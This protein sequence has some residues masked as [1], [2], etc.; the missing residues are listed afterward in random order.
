MSAGG[1]TG[2]DG[3]QAPA[4]PWAPAAGA[5]DTGGP[6]QIGDKPWYDVAISG[7]DDTAKGAREFFKTKNYRDP[8]VAARSLYELNKSNQDLAA[9]AIIPPGENATP[10]QV[11]AYYKK[12]GRPDNPEG[13][14]DVKWGDGADPKMV[15]FAQ[16]LAFDLG[17]SPKLAEGVMAKK[18]NDFVAAQNEEAANAG[19]AANEQYLAT[20]KTEW[21][22]DFDT[23]LAQGQRVMKALEQNGVSEADL[24][25]VE[26][27]IGVPQL[28]KV[29]ATIGKLTGEGG[30]M[31]TGS[32][33]AGDVDSMTPEA[34]KAKFDANMADEKFQKVYTDRMD[35]G[36][37]DATET[38][39]K[40]AAKAGN[41]LA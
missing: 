8:S 25:A 12:L 21:K 17:I 1:Q 24:A 39:L 10:E 14:K 4:V 22:G 26:A 13:Y 41:L 2:G 7:D 33:G 15:A 9:K 6:W 34:A 18:W 32:G 37:K 23:H 27:A 40:L 5:A 31:G 30:F 19:K 20:L 35:P 38:M 16:S 29:L 3:G 28:V 11:A 36:H